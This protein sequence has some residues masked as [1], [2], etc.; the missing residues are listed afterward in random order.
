[1]NKQTQP[2][3]RP[4]SSELI[5]IF[6]ELLP[7]YVIKGFFKASGKLFYQRLFSPVILIWCF[8]YQRLST[9]HTLDNILSHVESGAVDHL[10]NKHK[11]TVSERIAPTDTGALSKARKR[12]PFSVLQRCVE[13]TGQTTREMLPEQALWFGHHVGL[14]DGSTL[15]LRPFG[16]IVSHYGTHKNQH[17]NTYWALM[18]IV[19]VFCLFTGAVLSVAE[20]SL[21]ISEQDLASIVFA[22]AIAT[23]V[24]VGDRNF[25]IFKI[26]Q[27]ARHYNVFVLLRLTKDRVRSIA[28]R[29]GINK[30]SINDDKKLNWYPSKYDQLYPGISAFAYHGSLDIPLNTKRWF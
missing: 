6:K 24:Y 28:E 26:V 19:V 7:V 8:I 16:D 27:L 1:M 21:Y 10:D 18:R 4:N 2:K 14:L 11:Q 30:L 29:N 3:E 15:L 13:H 23:S 9:D 5:P 22:Q 20:G 17:G 12:L 25:G